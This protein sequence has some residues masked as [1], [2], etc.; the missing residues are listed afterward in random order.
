MSKGI[1]GEAD[2]V[3]LRQ[4]IRNKLQ[5]R[6][7]EAVELVLEEGLTETL[8]TVR[9]ER[10]EDRRGYRNGSET[11]RLTTALG[12]RELRVPR[13]RVEQPDGSTGEFHSRILSRYARR[14]K[15]VDEAILG[16]YLAGANTRRIRR[17]LA[18]LLGEAH[19]SKS[20]VSRVVARLKEQFRRW[21]E[22]GLADERYAML[23]LDGFH[24][25]VRM[26]RRVVSVPVLAALGVAEDGSKRL[27]ALQLAQSE[28]GRHWT[29]LVADLERWGLRPPVLVV[30][31]GHAGRSSFGRRPRSSVAPGISG[32]TLRGTARRTREQSC[33]GTTT[34]SPRRAMGWRRAKRT[35]RSWRSGASSAR[36]WCAASRKLESSC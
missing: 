31:D 5:R 14:T 3:R 34:R 2:V 24:L 4:D 35:A 7:L 17:A 36:R 33:N 6:V 21:S 27:V 8:G 9:Y 26:A 25:K 18:P 28:A 11:R 1:T 32:R 20:A 23:F 19:L 10:S 30:S 29:S 16:A 15:E 22:R 12:T 13:G